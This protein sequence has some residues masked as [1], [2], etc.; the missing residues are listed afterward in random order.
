MLGAIAPSLTRGRPSDA[1]FAAAR[2]N[3]PATRELAQAL[4]DVHAP[5][6]LV[7]EGWITG[8]NPGQHK[9]AQP[10]IRV[11]RGNDDY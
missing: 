10:S 3:V 6:D 11:T 9:V 7:A 1:D 4:A 8:A 5:A 2:V